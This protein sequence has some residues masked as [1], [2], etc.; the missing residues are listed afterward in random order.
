ME[1]AKNI[2]SL[3]DCSA[4]KCH[5]GGGKFLGLAQI[6]PLISEYQKKY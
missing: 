6:Y 5:L 4:E 2:I 3:K 1:N